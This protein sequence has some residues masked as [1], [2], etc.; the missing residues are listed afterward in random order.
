MRCR[1]RRFS[2]PRGL[3]GVVFLLF[4]VEVDVELFEVGV[5]VAHEG[6]EG[7]VLVVADGG[8]VFDVGAAVGVA[9]GGNGRCGGGGVVPLGQ[10]LHGVALEGTGVVVEHRGLGL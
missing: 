7:G 2:A 1:S 5:V 8:E 9:T 10:G 6:V 3:G 4:G